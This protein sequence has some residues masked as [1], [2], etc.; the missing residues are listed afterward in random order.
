MTN[1]I[2]FA[3]LYPFLIIIA[4]VY[5]LQAKKDD[6]YLYGICI[7]PQWLKE[8]AIL[9]IQKEFRRN[10]LICVLILA[11]LP[12][13]V[14][15][16]P[17]RDHFSLIYSV[18]MMWILLMIVL[19]YLPIQ[20]ASRRLSTWKSEHH[21]STVSDDDHWFLAGTMY[22]D[23]SN[24]HTIIETRFGLGTTVNTARPIGM[25]CLITGIIGILFLPASSGLM[26]AEEF[27][28]I[29]LSVED[30][31]LE[32]HHIRTDYEIPVADIT[33]VTLIDELPKWSK[34]TGSASDTL[35]KGTF[36]IRNV[37]KC[38]VFLNPQNDYFLHI[39]TADEDYYMSCATDQETKKL[40]H[41]LTDTPQ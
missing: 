5:Y 6:R 31:V 14:L 28:P 10:Y 35:D 9:Q 36:H 38:Q 3:T 15:L 37:G 1:I 39:T 40:F 24:P 33:H 29:Q 4:V 27:V 18:W 13:I 22:H 26:I 2:L 32:A 41:T 11:L 20:R 21:P 25:L 7:Q 23:P 12:L 30:Q 16:P 17:I 34:S 19:L 8:D